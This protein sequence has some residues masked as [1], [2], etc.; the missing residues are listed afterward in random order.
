MPPPAHLPSLRSE[1]SGNDPNINLVPTGSSGWGPKEEQERLEQMQRQ[2]QQQ[3]QQQQQ[4]QQSPPQA[5]TPVE[6]QSVPVKKTPEPGGRPQPS[7]L[8]QPAIP[9]HSQ[10]SPQ[11]QKASSGGVHTKKVSDVLHVLFCS[12]MMTA[13]VKMNC[14]SCSRGLLGVVVHH[15]RRKGQ[16]YHKGQT[17]NNKQGATHKHR[18]TIQTRLGANHGAVSL[19]EA[20]KRRVGINFPWLQSIAAEFW[21]FHCLCL[22]WAQSCVF[23]HFRGFPRP[24]VTILSRRISQSCFWRRRK[25]SAAKEGRGKRAT[26]WA[27]AK[28]KTTKYVLLSFETNCKCWRTEFVVASIDCTPSGTWL[29]NFK[30]G[31]ACFL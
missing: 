1:N 22:R 5:R 11:G 15:H 19:W 4:S 26:V 6:N 29:N 27:R 24:E 8:Q 9:P 20:T 28:L 3:Q 31:D 14:Y 23:S 16:T 7:S 10:Q 21:N 13:L 18:A 17:H 30:D 2:E 25:V 12:S